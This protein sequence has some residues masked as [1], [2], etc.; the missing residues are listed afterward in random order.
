MLHELAR[1]RGVSVSDVVR[2]TTRE[3]YAHEFGDR[4]PQAHPIRRRKE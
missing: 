4:R 2:M 1:K 3:S